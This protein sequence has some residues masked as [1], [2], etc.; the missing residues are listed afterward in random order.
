MVT[1]I[2]WSVNLGIKA[3]HA[4]EG[5]QYVPS[6]QPYSS[7]RDA[8]QVP[9]SSMCWLSDSPL[10]VSITYFNPFG[11][12]VMSCPLWVV[13]HSS[14]VIPWRSWFLFWINTRNGI[15]ASV[16]EACLY[17]FCIVAT[18]FCI[19]IGNEHNFQFLH[20]FTNTC[21]LGIFELAIPRY[22]NRCGRYWLFL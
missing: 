7:Q 12:S 19:P 15:A 20:I 16:F 8:F 21:P 18:Q 10:Y 13:L 3:P 11:W 17:S 2:Q 14:A 9:C 6:K 1:T 22:P 5:L 4:P